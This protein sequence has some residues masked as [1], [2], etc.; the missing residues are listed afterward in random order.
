ME[1]R[2]AEPKD[3]PAVAGIASN[4]WRDAYASLLRPST[5]DA[6][7][8][9]TYSPRAL[10]HRWEDHPIFLVVHIGRPIGFADAFIEDERICLSAL[11]VSPRHRRRGA[12]TL[13]LREVSALDGSLPV[14]SDVLLGARSAEL[15]YESHGFVPGETMKTILYGEPIVERR[16][17]REPASADL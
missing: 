7:L 14:T 8:Q 16:W 4:A 2:G 9:S 3:L 6:V 1:L 12:A 13:L 15:F 17:W 10:R 11:Y 5:I